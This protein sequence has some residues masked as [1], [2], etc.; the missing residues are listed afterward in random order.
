MCV[1]IRRLRVKFKN[2]LII[3]NGFGVSIKLLVRPTAKEKR[4]PSAWLYL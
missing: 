1:G 2:I 4:V 3:A